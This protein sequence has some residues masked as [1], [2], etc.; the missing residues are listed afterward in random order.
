MS[1]A[2]SFRADAGR[3]GLLVVD[4]QE[5]LAAAMP[6]KVMERVVQQIAILLQGAKELG[7]P[8][9]VTEQYRKG[10]GPTVGAIREH[11]PEGTEAFEKMEFS[12]LQ[13]PAI[14]EAIKAT[15]C[16]QWILCGMETHIC[17]FQ[18]T[19]DLCEQGYDVFIPEDSVISRAKTN[20][21]I[22]LRMMEVAGAYRTSTEAV[23]FDLL[24]KAGTP[25]FKVIS[26]LIK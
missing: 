7:L 26:K 2:K 4:V 24:V 17:V 16:D 9:L 10:I 19:R 15:G 13:N 8:I 14:A 18:T 23:L 1:K 21:R 25:S 3:T 11:L 12:C 6:D 5:R 22:G 20:W